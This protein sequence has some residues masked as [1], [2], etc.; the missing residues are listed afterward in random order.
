MI[1]IIQA[2]TPDTISQ[3]RI[4][5]REYEVWLGLKLCFQNF[6]EEVA[7]LPGKYSAPEGRLFLALT[8]RKPTGCIALRKLESGVCEMKRLFVKEIF[9][10]LGIG[11]L[12]IESILA[13]ARLIGYEK[14]RLDTYPPKMPRAVKMY[15]S[16]GFREIPPYYHNPYDGTIFMEKN[17]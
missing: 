15:E 13:E 12:L 17:L 3:S 10:G 14:M 16:Y 6:E 5:F 1:E 8:N 2:E 4:L 9:Q 7:E 11:K